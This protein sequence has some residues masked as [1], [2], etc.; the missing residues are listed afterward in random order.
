M[1]EPAD[2]PPQPFKIDPDGFYDEAVL[3]RVFRFKPAALDRAR[4]TG[5]LRHTRAGGAVLYRGQWLLEWL[6]AGA[7]PDPTPAA[8]PG[9]A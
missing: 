4:K 6:T 7:D 1:S 9:P 2:A 5:R 8:A 3:L